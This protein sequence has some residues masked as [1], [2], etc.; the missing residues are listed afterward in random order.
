MTH[1]P[2]ALFECFQCMWYRPEAGVPSRARDAK[3][4]GEAPSHYSQN[5]KLLQM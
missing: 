5:S 4:R 3:K 1:F 2:S